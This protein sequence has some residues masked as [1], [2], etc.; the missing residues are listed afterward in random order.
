MIA[1]ILNNLS[2]LH[3]FDKKMQVTSNNVANINTNG[4][5]KS[6]AVLKEGDNGGVKVDVHQ[7]KTSGYPMKQLEGNRVMETETSNVDLT[8]EFGERIVT[9]NAYSVNLNT[10]KTQEEMLGSLL[11]IFE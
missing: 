9:Q 2:A 4:F 6:Q 10:I 5:K 11:D 7:V 3:A 1:A 8:E